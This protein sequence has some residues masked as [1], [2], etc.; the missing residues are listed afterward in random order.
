[1][2]ATERDR[3]GAGERIDP[4]HVPGSCPP[5]SGVSEKEAEEK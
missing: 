5:L 3:E 1:M 4:D 2:N